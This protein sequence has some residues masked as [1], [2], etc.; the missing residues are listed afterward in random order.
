M[1]I[2]QEIISEIRDRADIVEV[3]SQYVELRRVGANF[4]ALCPFHDERSPSFTVSPDKQIFHC[5]GCGRGGNVFTFL[6]EIEGIA[7]PEAVRSLGRQLGIAV[8]DRTVSD[9]S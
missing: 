1:Q 2:P 4:S 7:F 5:F 9:E 3:V 6:M 8:P